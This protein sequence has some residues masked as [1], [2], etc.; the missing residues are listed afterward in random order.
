MSEARDCNNNLLQ[1][2]NDIKYEFRSFI[3][4]NISGLVHIHKY[5]VT[6]VHLMTENALQKLQPKM[7][8]PTLIFHF[9]VFFFYPYY[10]IPTDILLIEIIGLDLANIK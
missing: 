10:F 7:F 6:I 1:K 3:K 8:M 4:Y 5:G 2:T 9:F